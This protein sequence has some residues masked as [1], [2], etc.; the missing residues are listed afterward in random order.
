[1]NDLP[2]WTLPAGTCGRVEFEF[3]GAV[4]TNSSAL[5]LAITLSAFVIAFAQAKN[6]N[7][8]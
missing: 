5:A 7:L 3:D 1:M 2:A 6:A 8:A 4:D